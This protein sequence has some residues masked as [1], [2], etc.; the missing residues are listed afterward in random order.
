MLKTGLKTML[1]TAVAMTAF[2]GNS[3]F[4]QSV[5]TQQTATA[6]S[7]MPLLPAIP[8]APRG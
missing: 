4:S 8:S 2:A 3:H 5:D 7:L 1:L 6:R